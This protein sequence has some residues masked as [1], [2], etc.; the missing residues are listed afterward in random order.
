MRSYPDQSLQAVASYCL[1]PRHAVGLVCSQVDDC[2][3]LPEAIMRTAHSRSA[4]SACSSVSAEAVRHCVLAVEKPCT[5]RRGTWPDSGSNR[6][7]PPDY[8]QT[9][10]MPIS[11]GFFMR[12]LGEEVAHAPELIVAVVDQLRRGQS[13]VSSASACA[14][15]RAKIRRRAS[16][17][18]CA[19]PGGSGMMPSI[20]P[21][22]QQIG[23][24]QLQ[25][26]RLLPAPCRNRGR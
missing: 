8:R 6:R 2:R 24:G 7:S 11:T 13:P 19:P 5:P 22:L 23:G 3:S 17:S 12:A 4:A 1:Q 20:K 14:A 10:T 25:S 21:K 18:S 26:P 9:N 16:A 15:A